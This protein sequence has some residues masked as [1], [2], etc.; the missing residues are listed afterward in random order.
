MSRYDVHKVRQFD[1]EDVAEV[2]EFGPGFLIKVE[3]FCRGKERSRDSL[4]H[5]SAKLTPERAAVVHSCREATP[6]RVWYK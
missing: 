3:S 6:S 5:V 1:P 2:E 4:R